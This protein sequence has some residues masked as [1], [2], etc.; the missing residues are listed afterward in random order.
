MVFNEMKINKIFRDLMHQTCQMAKVNL[1][2]HGFLAHVLLTLTESGP[3]ISN[4][5]WANNEQKLKT[6][7]N[8]VKTISRLNCTLYVFVGEAN[9]DVIRLNHLLGKVL[10]EFKRF[11]K[12]NTLESIVIHGET[13]KGE[14]SASI[15]P[16]H[17]NILNNEIKYGK[18]IWVPKFGNY[19]MFRGIFGDR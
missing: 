19:Q 9:V 1:K 12:G 16:I 5:Q 4:L 8:C 7:K 6:I 11:K 17:K 15:T 10:H 3:Y 18:T 2:V 14:Q 13:R